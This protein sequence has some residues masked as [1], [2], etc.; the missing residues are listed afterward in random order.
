MKSITVN[1]TAQ[2]EFLNNLDRVSRRLQDALNIIALDTQN[3]LESIAR[4]EY[5]H[6]TPNS[7]SVEEL[8]AKRNAL[9][10]LAPAMGIEDE[11]M[12]AALTGSDAF[13]DIA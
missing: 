4:G 13:Y 7:S 8:A 5:C 1:T 6:F 2:V 9:I 12:H 10:E 11:W 3:Y